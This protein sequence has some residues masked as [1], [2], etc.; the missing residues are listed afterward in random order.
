VK[1]RL[2]SFA[3]LAGLAAAILAENLFAGELNAFF[4]R[5]PG[6]DKLLHTVEYA[7]VMI[8]VHALARR[9]PRA[10]HVNDLRIALAVAIAIAVLDESLQRLFPSRSVEAF[11][12]VANFAGIA[13]G[14]VFVRRPAPR[15]RFAATGLALAT[16]AFVAYDTHVKLIDYSRA[17]RYE[18]QHDFVRAREHYLRALAAG[19]QTPALFNELG[20]VEIESGVGDPHKAVEYAKTALDMQ[21]ANPDVVDT[22]GWALLHAGR[23]KEALAA[24][25]NA[26]AASPDMY[27]IHYHL[28]AAYLASGQHEKAKYH[29]ERQIEKPGTREAAF[30]RQALER[31]GGA[32]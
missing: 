25:Q 13:L 2:V 22:Y 17:M 27:C 30:A 23:T 28:G 19:L 11:D 31:L 15:V 7:L 14:W 29:F 16:A 24:L 26:Y 4:L 6:I 32:D 8:W 12:V 18:Q 3:G 9:T 10:T 20:W 1:R 21:P 5:F